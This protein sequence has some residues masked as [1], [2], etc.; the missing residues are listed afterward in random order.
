VSLSQLFDQ[1]MKRTDPYW[2]NKENYRVQQEYIKMLLTEPVVHQPLVVKGIE[3]D[4]G[5]MDV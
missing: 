1:Y 5:S 4:D 3:P 2:S